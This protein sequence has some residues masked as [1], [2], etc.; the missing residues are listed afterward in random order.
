M[1]A[2]AMPTYP[3]PTHA[4]LLDL[5]PTYSQSGMH[6][7]EGVPA[8]VYSITL[9]ADGQLRWNGEAVTQSEL[10]NLARQTLTEAQA[11]GVTFEPAANARY[12][13]VLT[14]LNILA[15]AGLTQ[16]HFCLKGLGQYHAYERQERGEPPGGISDEQACLPGL[17]LGALG[18]I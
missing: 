6:W 2:L 11:P 4:L 9:D 10:D 16:G 8:T 17:A 13:E 12:A 18:G 3:T 14:T 5:P 7:E 15:Q 1:V